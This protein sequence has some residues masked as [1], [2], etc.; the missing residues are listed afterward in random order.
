MG[1]NGTAR[2]LLEETYECGRARRI[3]GGAY[4]S[5]ERLPIFEGGGYLL[6]FSLL[7]RS[8]L[9]QTGSGQRPPS[10]ALVVVGGFTEKDQAETTSRVAWISLAKSASTTSAGAP[11]PPCSGT[12]AWPAASVLGP[13]PGKV[14][15]RALNSERS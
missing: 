4:I 1:V 7:K 8:P 10:V 15:V 11:A 3:G 2:C 12:P 6:V 14:S 9:A 5:R 13:R